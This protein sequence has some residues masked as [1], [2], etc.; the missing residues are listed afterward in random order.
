[1]FSSSAAA[2]DLA[3]AERLGASR[4]IRKPLDFDEFMAIGGTLKAM[5]SE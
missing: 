4:Y 1:V 3:D 5:M 2:R